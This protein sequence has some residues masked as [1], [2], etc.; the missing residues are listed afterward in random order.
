MALK[1]EVLFPAFW[2]CARSLGKGLGLGGTGG[3]SETC[4][5]SLNSD[6]DKIIRKWSK[7]G[8]RVRSVSVWIEAGSGQARVRSAVPKR[9]ARA[10]E[11]LLGGP[12][13]TEPSFV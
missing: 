3:S 1:W 4:A 9:L 10:S 6:S 2:G 11:P 13:G 5:G 7:Q 12:S 8:R